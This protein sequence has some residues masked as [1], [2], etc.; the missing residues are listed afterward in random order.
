MIFQQLFDRTSSTFTYLMAEKP[1]GEAVIIDPVFDHV[2]I[3]LS[4]LK[5]LNLKLVKAV[6]THVHA[7]HVTGLGALRDHTRC[8]TVM[9]EQ[10]GVDVVSMR[11]RDNET[12][13]AGGI[14]LTA[15]YT[16]GHT[17]DS[18]C[19]LYQDRVFTGDTLLIGGTGRTD[20]Q[21]G[22]SRAAYDSLFNKLLKLDDDTLVYP[23]HD[24]NGN[25]VTT[26]GYERACNPR[27]QV[28][29]AG[30][31]ADLMANLRL[32]D[33]RMMDVAI[34]ANRSIGR[35]LNR[36]VNPGEEISAEK[37]LREYEASDLIFV[38]LREDAERCRDGAIPG[39]IHIAYNQFDEQLKPSGALPRL[40]KDHQGRVV[41][42]CAFGE[43]SALVLQSAREAGF[44][45]LRHMTGG[46][47]AW[48]RAGGKVESPE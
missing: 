40:L 35:T 19:F 11:I 14:G 29:S 33:P 8:V 26:I 17:D 7:D 21:N 47:A 43:R 37:C 23:A 31:Y 32:D 20:F 38:D 34:P 28:G 25:T 1:G 36:F 30:E 3:Y 41:L 27:L 22:D 18:Y 6:D 4:L 45:G 5:R 39:S 16:P 48:L 2:D 42:Y 46:L 12:I 10:S 44:Q 15:M 9:G 24:Y 13:T